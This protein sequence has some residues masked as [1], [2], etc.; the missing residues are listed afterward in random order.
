MVASSVAVMLHDVPCTSLSH[1]SSVN[2]RAPSQCA[3]TPSS[4]KCGG[5]TVCHQGAPL[6]LAQRGTAA[7]LLSRAAKSFKARTKYSLHA[8]SAHSLYLRSGGRA[9]SHRAA[10]CERL[11]QR[12]EHH[13]EA[14]VSQTTSH[15]SWSRQHKQSSQQDTLSVP[16][17]CMLAIGI[18]CSRTACLAM[19]V[20]AKTPTPIS[21][22]HCLSWS[23]GESLALA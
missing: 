21:G 3:A 12:W 8:S 18:S 11:K 13:C 9:P 23:S 7:S 6:R 15:L 16:N 14:H 10:W 19:A 5:I 2:F 20:V 22:A 17:S 4:S 1:C